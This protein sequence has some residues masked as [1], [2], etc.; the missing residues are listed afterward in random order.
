[1]A[2]VVGKLNSLEAGK[3]QIIK[4]LELHITLVP[5]K[6]SLSHKSINLNRDSPKD[7][8]ILFIISIVYYDI[9]KGNYGKEELSQCISKLNVD[10]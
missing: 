7:S 5:T 2:L 10:T 8:D 1:M 3:L 4:S 9:T 6:N